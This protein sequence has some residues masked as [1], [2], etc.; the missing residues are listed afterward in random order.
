VLLK[1]VGNVYEADA[2]KQ[3][4]A[5][6]ITFLNPLPCS[7]GYQVTVPDV[8]QFLEV[9]ELLIDS[10][11]VNEGVAIVGDEVE[12]YVVL[13]KVPLAFKN[14]LEEPPEITKE[15]PTYSPLE[16]INQLLV[17]GLPMSTYG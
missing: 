4:F 13:S 3:A 11:V 7:T 1:A 14:W 6:P 8:A 10:D 5:Y 17:D 9:P 12:A 16:Y 15:V 2:P